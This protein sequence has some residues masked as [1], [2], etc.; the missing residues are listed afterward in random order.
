MAAASRTSPV[1]RSS[2]RTLT[3]RPSVS[4]SRSRSSSG[5]VLCETPMARSSLTGTLLR[6]AGELAQLS[7]HPLEADGHDPEVDQEQGDE[8][9]I[10]TRHVLAGLVEGQGGHQPALASEGIVGA[11]REREATGASA[12]SARRR[13]EI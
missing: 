1:S 6:E 9:E 8:D 4:A 3:A 7:L 13:R 2:E 11:I 10:G 5:A 12:S